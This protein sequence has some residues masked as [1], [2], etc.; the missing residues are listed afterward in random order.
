MFNVNTIQ[1][2]RTNFRQKLVNDLALRNNILEIQK[3]KS[4]FSKKYIDYNPQS[5]KN[6]S[7]KR[8]LNYDGKQARSSIDSKDYQNQLHLN[9]I[10][11]ITTRNTSN[12]FIIPPPR[13]SPKS[14]GRLYSPIQNKMKNENE[15]I[16]TENLK[17]FNKLVRVHSPL[18][19]KKMDKHYT[20]FLETKYR[21]SKVKTFNL[22]PKLSPNNTLRKF[23]SRSSFHLPS[24]TNS[25]FKSFKK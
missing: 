16:T 24:L 22:S 4:Q 19:K 6:L 7:L 1:S 20:N 10:K 9:R 3:R 12:K 25:G 2:D 5:I 14:S 11:N 17:F 8:L 13:S 15:R 18:N 23:G 21:I